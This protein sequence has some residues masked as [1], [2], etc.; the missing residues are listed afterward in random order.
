MY[1]R[2]RWDLGEKTV[3]AILVTTDMVGIYPNISHIEGLE[4]LRKQYH[5]FLHQKVRTEGIIE[6][7]ENVLKKVFLSLISNFSNKYV[8]PLLVLNLLPPPYDCIFMDFIETE[9][10]KTQS[11]KLSVWKRFIDDIFFIWTDSEKNLEK[12]LKELNRFHPNIKFT[13]EKSKM[14]VNFLD[15]ITEIKNGRLSTELCSK[16]VDS[17]QYLHYNSCHE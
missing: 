11:I 14:K 16:L 13:F 15:V 2:Y 8:E 7:A 5:K 17:Y 10:L 1:I 9:L 4:V 3:G 6:M 12:C